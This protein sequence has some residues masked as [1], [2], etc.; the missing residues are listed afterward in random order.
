MWL[1]QSNVRVMRNIRLPIE[2]LRARMPLPR[3]YV[4]GES[5]P[6][7]HPPRAHRPRRPQLRRRALRQALRRT[8]GPAPPPVRR[9]AARH[10][11]PSQTPAAHAVHHHGLQQAGSERFCCQSLY[12]TDSA[13][14]KNPHEA[15]M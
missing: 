13:L 9:G 15:C 4:I 10:R 3:Q 12:R 1:Q 14:M 8:A 5:L 2:R 7:L 11:C 6:A